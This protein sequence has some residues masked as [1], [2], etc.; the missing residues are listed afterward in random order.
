VVPVAGSGA[1]SDDAE[2]RRLCRAALLEAALG[3]ADPLPSPWGFVHPPPADQ[4]LTEEEKKRLT[5]QRGEI[6]KLRETLAPLARAL[7]EQAAS[8][9]RLLEKDDLEGCLTACKVL[10]TLGDVRQ[11]LLNLDVATR[12]GAAPGSKPLDD[13]LPQLARGE[14]VAAVAKLLG[15]KDVRVRLGAVYVL[16]S[17]ETAAAP[18]AVSVVKATADEDPFVRWGAARVLGRMAP[19]QAEAVVPALA[20]LLKDDNRD[21][22]VT[23]LAALERYGPAAKDAVPALGEVVKGDGDAGVRLAAIK[24][25]LAVGTDARKARSELRAV[26]VGGDA[27]V[28]AA[29]A[30]ALGRLGATE[31]ESKEA[32]RKALTD[33][34]AGV[35]EAASE[36]L[37][38]AS[39]K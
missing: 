7:D 30:R 3:M 32:L 35:R 21:V 27:S 31:P 14:T 9:A 38:R 33:S 17:L 4:P 37:L 8:L 28:R 23:A 1:R 15:H 25:L 18:A 29:A 36:A 22:L 2:V 5:F 20:K 10:E 6:E 11:R 26:L 24:A 39:E 13:P 19:R 34:D 16:E 12:A